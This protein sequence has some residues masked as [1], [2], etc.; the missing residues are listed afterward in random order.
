M[1]GAVSDL[2]LGKWRCNFMISLLKFS[3]ITRLP[4]QIP[5]VTLREHWLSLAMPLVGDIASELGQ[6]RCIQIVQD[7]AAQY[8]IDQGQPGC[9]I[10]PNSKMPAA[11]LLLKCLQISKLPLRRHG[12]YLTIVKAIICCIGWHSSRR[13]AIFRTGV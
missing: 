2:F 1:R 12:P 11:M 8:Q 4:L 7:R 9:W 6:A 3:K 13:M 10:A 5:S